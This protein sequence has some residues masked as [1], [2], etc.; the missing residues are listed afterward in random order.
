MKNVREKEKNIRMMAK[1]N[2]HVL[3][4][5]SVNQKETGVRNTT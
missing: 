3:G 1:Q 2:D 4:L 5:Q